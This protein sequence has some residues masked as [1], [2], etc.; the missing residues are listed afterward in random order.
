[1]VSSITSLSLASG[2]EVSILMIDLNYLQMR[3]ISKILKLFDLIIIIVDVHYSIFF[4]YN[5]DA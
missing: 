4:S 1:M 5:I 3:H 2:E